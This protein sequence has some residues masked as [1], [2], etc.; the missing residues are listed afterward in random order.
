M[1]GKETPVSKQV[2]LTDNKSLNGR[3]YKANAMLQEF[4]NALLMLSSAPAYPSLFP[5]IMHSACLQASSLAYA[6]SVIALRLHHKLF[7]FLHPKDIWW[8]TA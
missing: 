5:T 6:S 8:F 7:S 1:Y 3:R 4:F 2:L